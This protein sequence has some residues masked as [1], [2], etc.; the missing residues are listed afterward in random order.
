MAPLPDLKMWGM[1]ALMLPVVGLGVAESGRLA[2]TAKITAQRQGLVVCA[3]I[4]AWLLTVG[5]LAAGGVFLNF[6]A[7]PP[8]LPA[9]PLIAFLTGM[10]LM[11][12]PVRDTR[13]VLVCVYAECEP[14]LWVSNQWS[15]ICLQR[16]HYHMQLCRS[17]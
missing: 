11:S 2:G 12:R 7:V 13:A 8:R 9:V 3:A 4:A 10:T 1:A 15:P 16:A 6:D 17:S 5:V 14:P